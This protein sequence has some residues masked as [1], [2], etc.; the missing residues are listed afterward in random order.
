LPY[1]A[2]NATVALVSMYG[3]IVR[4]LKV[5]ADLAR[6]RAER[7]DAELQVA[8]AENRELERQLSEAAA[9]LEPASGAI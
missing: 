3:E 1:E 2:H 4:R 8:R 5:E 9:R 7:L 6:A